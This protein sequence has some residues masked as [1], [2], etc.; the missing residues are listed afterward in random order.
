[1][2]G[3]IDDPVH[4]SWCS[5]PALTTAGE[6]RTRRFTF[7]EVRGRGGGKRTKPRVPPLQL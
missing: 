3:D 4:P 2:L 6:L 1:M 7:S 5:A